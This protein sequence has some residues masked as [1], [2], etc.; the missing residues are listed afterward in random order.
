MSAPRTRIYVGNL[1]PVATDKDLEDSFKRFGTITDIW[2]ARKPPGFAFV[3]FEDPRDAEDAVAEMNGRSICG[4]R[5]RVEVSTRE[6]KGPNRGG[7][8]PRRFNDDYGRRDDYGGRGGGG[9]RSES[10]RRGRSGERDR[11]RSP[12]YE[13][14]GFR[15]RPRSRSAGRGRS[16]PKQED[17]RPRRHSPSRSRS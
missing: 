1:D 8:G 3:S 16:P 5:V 17:D 9:R 6:T 13:R 11:R 12:S 7:G 14:G 2:V 4:Q 10:P 15:D